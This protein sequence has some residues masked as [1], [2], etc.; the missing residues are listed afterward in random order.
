[1]ESASLFADL[2]TSFI[3][4][5]VVIPSIVRISNEKNFFD[6]PNRRKLNKVATPT[7]GGVAI[8]IGLVLGSILFLKNHFFPEW[9]YLF[10]SIIMMLF[11]GL[12]D[13]LMVINAWK[14]FSIQLG[15][16]LILVLM[17]NFRITQAYELFSFSV[18]AN[19]FSIPLS[20][21]VILFLINAI[22]LIDG[23][24]GLAAALSLLVSLVLGTWFCLT[25]NTGYAIICIAL[26]GS[27][28]AFLRFNLSNGPNKIF[29]GD[30]GSLVLGT[31]LAAIAIRFNEL[32]AIASSPF[33]FSQAPVLAMALLI[34]PTTDT[35]RVFTIRILKKRSPFSPDKNHIHHLLIKAGLSHVQAT[36][37]LLAYTIIFTLLALTFQY[38]RLNITAS[39][40]LI[41]TLSFSS[42]QAIY[43]VTKFRIKRRTPDEFTKIQT[44][45]IRL[46][47]LK[48]YFPP[49]KKN[50]KD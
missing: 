34:V 44:K 45:I 29:M 36:G 12:V 43:G 1:M 32:N 19:W 28:A 35:L 37:F 27:L 17:G 3:I 30:T 41:L 11:V 5:L 42:V 15:A 23:I 46:K 7:L 6:V 16:A 10:V 40:F 24:D 20:V 22:N 49:R 14:K 31:F 8:F 4:T 38:L 21:I 39:F 9:Q 13:D 47:P 26:C 25:G 48:D 18:F 33:R 50:Y 2:I